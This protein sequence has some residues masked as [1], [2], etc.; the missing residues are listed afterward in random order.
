MCKEKINK[1]L[2]KLYYHGTDTTAMESASN[3]KYEI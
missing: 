3:K 2:E 1:Q